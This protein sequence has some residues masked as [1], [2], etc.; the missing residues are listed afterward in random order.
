MIGESVDPAHQAV[1][2]FGVHRSALRMILEYANL[3]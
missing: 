3:A 1:Q 2:S